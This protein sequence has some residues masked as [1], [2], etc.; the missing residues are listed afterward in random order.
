MAL[1]DALHHSASGTCGVLAW[2][3]DDHMTRVGNEFEASVSVLRDTAME[4]QPITEACTACTSQHKHRHSYER[5]RRFA[6][7]GHPTYPGVPTLDSGL[8]RAS[9]AHCR[10]ETRAPARRNSTMAT[11]QT[12]T[13]RAKKSEERA[14]CL[15]RHKK[16]QDRHPL[17]Q[18]SHPQPPKQT[19]MHNTAWSVGRAVKMGNH[20]HQP[21]SHKSTA[22]FTRWKKQP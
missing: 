11:P 15:S 12:R 2:L 9:A 16:T 5:S 7:S 4:Q 8:Q 17:P 1:L 18:S 13:T 6:A 3:V 10:S 19:D 22:Q 20:R 14:S 21:Q